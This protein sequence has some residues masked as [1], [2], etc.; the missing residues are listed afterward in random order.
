MAVSNVRFRTPLYAAFCVFTALLIGCQPSTKLDELAP[1]AC[2]SGFT[3]IA[4]VQGEGEVSP[5]LDAQV[6]V[7]G[8]VTYIEQSWGSAS[9]TISR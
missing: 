8:I 4:Q 9:I 6:T 2:D 3:S 1:A 7:K 5:M